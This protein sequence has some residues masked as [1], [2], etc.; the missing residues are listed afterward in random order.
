MLK[1]SATKHGMT[2]FNGINRRGH[3]QIN[4]S[5]KKSLYNWV[6]H[7]PQVVESPFKNYCLRASIDYHTGKQLVP[8]LVFQV[9]IRK[10]H[11]IMAGPNEEGGLQKA[12][13]KKIIISDSELHTILTSQLKKISARHR[14]MC[15]CE[16]CIYDKFMHY[17]LSTF[18][19]WY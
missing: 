6:L 14:V 3:T 19:D 13:Y 12:R 16:C 10:L 7:N 15:G 5:V 2:A 17:Y 18:L 4:K 8:K 1:Q 9:S 11:N